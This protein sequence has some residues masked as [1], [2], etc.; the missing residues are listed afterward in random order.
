MTKHSEKLFVLG[1]EEPLA[2]TLTFDQAAMRSLLSILQHSFDV[3][4]VDLPRGVS[5]VQRHVLSVAD[6][7]IVATELSLAGVRDC[8]RVKAML[9]E[10]DAN[11]R[12]IYVASALSGRKA[13]AVK[14][15]DFKETVG[16]RLAVTLPLDEK[17]LGLA[18]TASKPVIDVA[19]N[20]AFLKALRP[21]AGEI[22]GRKPLGA[23]EPFW[24]RFL[25]K[26]AAL[27]PAKA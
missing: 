14:P 22:T 21:L 20:S 18:A 27:K 10:S 6:H 24:R 7:V 8:L 11:G 25:R 12:P 15:S 9:K 2:H 13:A 3:V 23:A 26:P 1:A 16:E 19:K 4:I 5:P 17:A